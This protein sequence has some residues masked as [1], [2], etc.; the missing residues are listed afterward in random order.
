MNRSMDE[1]SEYWSDTG[2]APTPPPALPTA[3]TAASVRSCQDVAPPPPPSR[4]CTFVDQL[5][6]PNR[7]VSG[8][9]ESLEAAQAMVVVGVID[10]GTSG[11]R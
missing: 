11:P 10:F 2:S 7:P 3:R 6:V 1:R 9:E 8:V 5:D 4:P